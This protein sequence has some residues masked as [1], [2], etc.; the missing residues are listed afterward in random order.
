MLEDEGESRFWGL[1]VEQ[2][3]LGDRASGFDI[4]G[5]VEGGEGVERGIGAGGFDRADR[6]A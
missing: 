6:A 5:I 3:F 4:R 2:G 1:G